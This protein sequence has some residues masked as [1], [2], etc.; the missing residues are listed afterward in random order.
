MGSTNGS[1]LPW[2]A[3]YCLTYLN[4]RLDRKHRKRVIWWEDTTMSCLQLV[5]IRYCMCNPI[6]ARWVRPCWP[7]RIEHCPGRVT[8]RRCSLAISVSWV[9]S[10]ICVIE[11][12]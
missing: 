5:T 6:V 2:E 12:P 3:N 4:A 11:D 9:R 1:L 10:I 7:T 8:T